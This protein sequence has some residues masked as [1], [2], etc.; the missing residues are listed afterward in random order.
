MTGADAFRSV[1]GRFATGV[2][3]VTADG[4][5]GPVGMTANA[6]CSLSLE[7]L[8][9]LVCF[10][11]EARTLPIVRDQRRFGVNVLAEGQDDLAR[12]FASK[13][14]GKFDEVL[15]EIEDGIP[16]IRGA[17][18]WVAC[19][20][21]ELLGS[22]LAL[23]LLFG[24]PMAIGVVAALNGRLRPTLRTSITPAAVQAPI[25]MS[26]NTGCSGWPSQTPCRKSTAFCRSGKASRTRSTRR[27]SLSAI[28][29]RP[30]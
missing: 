24:I 12:R 26:V 3:V 21:A 1:M 9:V 5:D 27:F 10:D 17:I 29:S 25:G 14:E 30:F 6:V 19:D 2:T 16:V 28:V 22:A 20:L 15:H 4:P 8:L 18:A 23:N 7:P 11:R 13:N